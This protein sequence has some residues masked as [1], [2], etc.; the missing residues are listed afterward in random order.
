VNIVFD[1]AGVLLHWQ[2]LPLLQ[3]VLPAR[4]ASD[5]EAAA[6]AARFFEGYGGDWGQFDRGTLSPELLVPRIARR[7]GLSEAEVHAVMAAVFD[8]LSP[9]AE[10]VALLHTLRAAGHTLYYLSNMPA[11]YA[12]HLLHTHAFFAEFKAGVFS[13]HVQL[14]KPESA[15][16][17]LAANRFGLDGQPV[18]FIDDV[19]ANVQAAQ[20]FG[21]Q[22][23]QFF[24]A[25][26]CADALRPLLN[27]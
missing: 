19:L 22:A 7:T 4:A 13:S 3:R 6:L 16:F 12:A 1:L 2:P 18:V 27:R 10:T 20:V 23:L 25:A 5:V 11:P 24:S 8:E 17:A 21:W 15:I 9:Q 26:Q 14:C